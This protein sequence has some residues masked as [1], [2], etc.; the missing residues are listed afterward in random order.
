MKEL[1]NMNITSAPNGGDHDA[2]H[3]KLGTLVA[4]TEE[5]LKA[6]NEHNMFGAMAL[7]AGVGI[8]ALPVLLGGGG[9]GLAFGGE[10]VGL[11]LA[12]VAAVGGMSG[13]TIGKI[14]NKPRTGHMVDGKHQT[15]TL[16]DM[17]GV[18]QG[19]D[20]RWWDQPG[21]DVK[22]TWQAR[23]AEGRRVVFTEYHNPE[24]LFG[25]EDA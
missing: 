5:G 13:G 18:V 10:A 1:R 6:H 3:L 19:K 15:L 25:L 4:I 2:S 8:V 23:N 12:E 20:R 17:V 22:V 21:Y 9:I 14:V 24:V 7:G 11:G 16:V